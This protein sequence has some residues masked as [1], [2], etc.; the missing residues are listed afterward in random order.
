MPEKINNNIDIPKKQ[1]IS[2][3]EYSIYKQCPFRWY[4][5][6]YLGIK[7]P[8][9]EF[10]VFGSS[11]HE[12]IE[13]IL[14]DPL[15]VNN[16]REIATQKV[17]KNGNSAFTTS[18]FG[19]TLIKDAVGV[20]NSLDFYNRFKGIDI[21]GIEENIYEPLVEVNGE[22][23]YFKGFIDFIGQYKKI[24]KY[25]VLDWKSALREWNLEKKVGK[26]PFDVIYKKIKNKEELSKEEFENLRIKIFFGQTALYQ[27]FLSKKYDIDIDKIDVEYCALTRQPIGI[28]EYRV[29]ITEDFREWVLEDIKQVAKEIYTFK[30]EKTLPKIKIEK[31]LKKYCDYCFFKKDICTDCPKQK[32]IKEDI[33]KKIK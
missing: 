14:K 11:V 1:H 19:K 7:E 21:A 23:I 10:L 26:I 3:S 5:Q 18:F 4:L 33:I 8:T 31:G 32:V 9:N 13:E 30:D 24:D 27:Y 25:I 20:V 17:K 28:K 16:I 6:Y 2:F 15:K 29:N 22:V 12:T